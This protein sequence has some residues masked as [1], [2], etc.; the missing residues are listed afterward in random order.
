MPASPSR[1]PAIH[2]IITHLS[3][4]LSPWAGLLPA[5]LTVWQVWAILMPYSRSERILLLRATLIALNRLSAPGT[6]WTSD[7]QVVPRAWG[8]PR[9]AACATP[10]PTLVSSDHTRGCCGVGQAW[11]CPT[12]S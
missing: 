12:G 10:P 3:R 4:I 9:A 8:Q 11:T 2:P 7:P 1:S 5:H 6:T